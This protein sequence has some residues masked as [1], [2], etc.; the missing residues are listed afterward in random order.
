MTNKTTL[1]TFVKV[2]MQRK[3]F[4]LHEIIYLQLKAD[5]KQNFILKN[6]LE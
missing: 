3:K 4:G 6:D 1:Y 2:Y 5:Y